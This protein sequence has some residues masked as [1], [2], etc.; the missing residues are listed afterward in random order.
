MSEPAPRSAPHNALEPDELLFRSLF[1]AVDE[2]IMLIE[3]VGGRRDWRTFAMNARAAAMLDEE[4]AWHD[5]YDQ[6]ADTGEAVRFERALSLQ[7]TIL[8]VYVARTTNVPAPRLLVL[9]RDVTK[10][11]QAREALQASEERFRTLAESIEDVFYMTDLEQGRLEY[12]S[13]SY[14]QVWGRSR[15]ELLRDLS[16]FVT[17][18]HP[19]DR[20]S[21]GRNKAAQLRGAPVTSEYRIVRPD[22]AVRWIHDR[23]FPVSGA[24]GR[25]SAGV[26]SDVTER[27]ASARALR[28]S[29]ERLR[30]LLTGIP[31]LVWS[32]HA[33][34]LWSWASP[35]WTAYTGQSAEDS[36]GLGWLEP[37]HPDD[38]TTA[39][40]RWAEAERRG[41]LEAE[42]RIRNAA[43]D[44]Y[45]WF[46][47]RAMPVRDSDG[48]IVEWL[49][50][51]TDVDELRGLQQRQ[52]RLLAE[53]QHRVRNTLG[54][55]KT[56]AR[57]TAESSTR[58]DD[59]A[60]HLDGRI[61]AFARVQ[62]VVTRDPGAGVDLTSIIEDEL[63]AHAARDG[64]QVTIRGPEVKLRPRAA[65]SISLAVHELA[66]NAVKHG[67]LSDP[68]GLIT[69]QWALD[70]GALRFSWKEFG[71]DRDLADPT[72][73]GFGL[74]LL[75]RSLPYD[76]K[77]ETQ[78]AFEPGGLR[79]TLS[80]PSR[81]VLMKESGAPS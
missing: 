23:S 70:S 28:E 45:C 16:G 63:L 25:R 11:H 4:T 21:F 76:L 72:T 77:A 32:A 12:L 67:A 51:S 71:V 33:P 20:E 17:T 73:E 34:A 15:E 64:R 14:E 41:V 5:V 66:T 62:S 18:I 40:E 1:E 10:R 36:L 50:T 54:V 79:F 31:Q 46:Q 37:V 75:L 22:G 29:E 74:E 80:A 55:I 13:P 59:L 8:Q 44:R 58:V 30:T 65:E 52:Q 2:G 38:R 57:R 61:E 47:T 42:Y 3:R 81:A 24:E 27:L 35:Q 48:R 68:K 60:A 69:I 56:M 19:D 6:V 26:A 43:L 9:L 7:A 49:G 78:V 39:R 53:L